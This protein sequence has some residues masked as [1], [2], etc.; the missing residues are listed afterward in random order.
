[1]RVLV[2]VLGV[3]GRV[4]TRMM[5]RAHVIVRHAMGQR[6]ARSGEAR[7]QREDQRADARTEGT[8]AGHAPSYP[9]SA[10]AIA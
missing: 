5:R 8:G 6:R 2:V 4:A 3:V 7:E 1:M 10:A 9:A